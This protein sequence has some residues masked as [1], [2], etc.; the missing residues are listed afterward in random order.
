MTP[1]SLSRFDL[2]SRHPTISKGIRTIRV[3]LDY[4]DSVL[5]KDIQAFSSY[6]AR[7]FRHL[8]RRISHQIYEN[9][10]WR[11]PLEV[12]DE[13][14]KEGLVY[15]R[16]WTDF[17]NGCVHQETPYLTV[18]REAHKKY[19]ANFVIQE[20]LRDGDFI[21]AVAAGF[22]RM[23]MA[24]TLEVRD[25][26]SGYWDG[27]D[28]MYERKGRPPYWEI[29]HDFEAMV[30]SM[31]FPMKWEH[32]RK[33]ELGHPC[34]DQLIRLPAAIHRAGGS[35]TS[36]DIDVSGPRDLVLFA[37]EKHELEKLTNSIQNLKSF[38]FIFREESDGISVDDWPPRRADETLHVGNFLACI[39]ST[40]SLQSLKM[41][42]FFLWNNE[43]LNLTPNFLSILDAKVL[44]KWES[45]SYLNLT[46]LP[47][48]RQDIEAL[49]KYVIKPQVQIDFS[50]ILLLDSE[51]DVILEIMHEKTGKHTRFHDLRFT[52]TASL[53]VEMYEA[54]RA[55]SEDSE[56]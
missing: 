1:K 24:G 32:S 18:L 11:M 22:G 14:V 52:D 23:P 47:I 31:V 48:R 51:W 9:N 28:Q 36:F 26:R 44:R 37:T 21:T 3:F 55:D 2:F 40:S 45:I 7:H 19:Q 25:Y 29:V 4:Y 43:D 6:H 16:E 12:L 38:S 10:R 46:F 50:R 20:K 34:I 53:W 35:V 15:F 27:S 33:G 5:A 41:N 39:L 8:T 56:K 30:E 54:P 17:S 13:A 49:T 42:L